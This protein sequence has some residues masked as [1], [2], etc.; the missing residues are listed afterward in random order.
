[1][2]GDIIFIQGEQQGRILIKSEIPTH[3]LKK[4]P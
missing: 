4:F 2:D 1:M 3:L